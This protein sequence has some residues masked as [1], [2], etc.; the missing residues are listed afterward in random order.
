MVNCR[1]LLGRYDSE[2]YSMLNRIVAIDETWI[3]SFE[4]ELKRQSSEWHTPNSPRPVKFRR[5]M[6]CPKMLMI[7]AYDSIGVLASYRV[8]NGKTVNTECYHM[9]LRSVICPAIRRKRPELLVV[10]PF[11]LHDNASCHKSGL[12][13]ALLD[14]K[15]SHTRLIRLTYPHPA[16][17]YSQN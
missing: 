11:I 4:P 9:F 12:V 7:F 3:R 16:S 14:G 13:K 6:N 17:I 5:S 15:F 1:Q 2:Q 10:G 8:P